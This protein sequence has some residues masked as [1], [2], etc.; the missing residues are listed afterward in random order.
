M[1]HSGLPLLLSLPHLERWSTPHPCPPS[2]AL[3]NFAA[4]GGGFSG[5]YSAASVPAQRGPPSGRPPLPP[6]GRPGSRERPIKVSPKP[7]GCSRAPVSA[8]DLGVSFYTRPPR[9]RHPPDLHPLAGTKAVEAWRRRA[10][11]R[12]RCRCGRSSPRG[13]TGG[14]RGIEA[15]VLDEYTV[16]VARWGQP[17][18]AQ[19]RRSRW[20]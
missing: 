11:G 17:L 4:A 7:A 9:P 13:A 1:L 8:T 12:G 2:C 15:L 6:L 14:A 5:S 16:P 20:M 3:S 19:L 10:E 18:W